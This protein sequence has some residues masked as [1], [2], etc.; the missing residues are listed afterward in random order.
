MICMLTVLI[1][2]SCKTS[3]LNVLN[4]NYVLRKA[5]HDLHPTLYRA[6]RNYC[7][8]PIANALKSTSVHIYYIMPILVLSRAYALL[9]A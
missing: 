9:L 4:N 3:C 5:H 2:K 8:T 1:K 6:L 7:T